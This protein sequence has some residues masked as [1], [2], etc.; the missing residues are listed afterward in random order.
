MKKRG[1]GWESK[2]EAEGELCQETLWLRGRKLRRKRD[3]GTF[4]KERVGNRKKLEK[5]E[6]YRKVGS[7][8]LGGWRR[9]KEEEEEEGEAEGCEWGMGEEVQSKVLLENL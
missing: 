8:E 4:N 9:G 2:G 7:Q 5:S 6:V 3:K 1:K